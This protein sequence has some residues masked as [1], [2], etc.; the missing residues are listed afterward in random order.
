MLTLS[1]FVDKS[2]FAVKSVAQILRRQDM[3]KTD[4]ER[5][6]PRLWAVLLSGML[7]GYVLLMGLYVFFW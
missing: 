5:P 1:A 6:R 7:T 4:D 2:A 3:A